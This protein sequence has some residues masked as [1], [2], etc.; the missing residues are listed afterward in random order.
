MYIFGVKT[1]DIFFEF[2][3]FLDEP[4]TVMK[5]CFESLHHSFYIAY[6]TI[7]QKTRV[8]ELIDSEFGS[9]HHRKTAHI[10]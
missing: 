2:L 5:V 10:V 9:F 1:L 7:G 8:N 4:D 3:G 6:L